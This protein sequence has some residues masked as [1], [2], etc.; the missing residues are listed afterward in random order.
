VAGKKESPVYVILSLSKSLDKIHGPGGR[1]GSADGQSPSV[2]HIK[3]VTSDEQESR[4]NSGEERGPGG[5]KQTE[6][7]GGNAG[8]PTLTIT[9]AP[10]TSPYRLSVVA[11]E[12]MNQFADFENRK[13][14]KH[15][16]LNHAMSQ[17]GRQALGMPPAE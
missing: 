14:L 10:H 15:R 6:G 5:K 2:T 11:G 1:L 12:N 3:A 13:S 4:K 9:R 17:G 8:R 16:S 7:E